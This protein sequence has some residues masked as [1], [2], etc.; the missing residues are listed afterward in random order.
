MD[1]RLR[2]A[3][4]FLPLLAGALPAPAGAAGA[5]RTASSPPTLLAY[6]DAG[7]SLPVHPAEFGE[8]WNVGWSAGAGLGIPLSPVWQLDAHFRYHR[9][10]ADASRQSGD[11]LLSGPGG[12]LVPVASIDGRDL[13]I[14]TLMAELRFL[15]PT[16]TPQ[17][18]W[19]LSFGAGAGEVYTSDASVTSTDETMDPIVIVGDSDGAF[20]SSMG[21]GVELDLSDTL[22]LTVDSI[23]TIVF[24]E[25]TATQFLP[26]RVGL[27]Y[28]VP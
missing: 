14:L 28:R 18:T 3:L 24:T 6:L 23:Y 13:T 16:D 22:R 5:D 11:L 2:I 9:H 19:F 12:I 25:Q 20:A 26:L 7:A 8:F 15:V 1:A 21:G 10:A 17:R 4:L 27:A